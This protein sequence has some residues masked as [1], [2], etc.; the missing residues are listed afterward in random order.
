M[1]DPLQSSQ[2]LGRPVPTLLG[3]VVVQSLYRAQVVKLAAA[4]SAAAA[5]AGVPQLDVVLL[6]VTV[7]SW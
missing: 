4:T 3:M 7:T 2:L 6:T 5:P 1:L